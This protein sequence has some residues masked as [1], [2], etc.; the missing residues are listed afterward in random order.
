MIDELERIRPRFLINLGGL[1]AR[2]CC[3]LVPVYDGFFQRRV[4]FKKQQFTF[5]KGYYAPVHN[6]S[7]PYSEPDR[8]RVSIIANSSSTAQNY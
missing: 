5:E 2:N 1:L 7:T 3:N 4:I 8:L 6:T